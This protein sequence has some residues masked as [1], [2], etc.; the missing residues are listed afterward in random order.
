MTIKASGRSALILATGLFACV[1]GPSQATAVADNTAA[2]SK[3][4]SAAAAPVALN[5]Y[6]RHGWHHARA[7]VHRQ[8]SKLASKSSA[9]KKAADDSDGPAAIPPSVANANAELMPA[10]A[11]G[12]NARAMT[13]RADD[14]LQAASD[15]PVPAQPAAKTQVV[16]ADQLNDVDRALQEGQPPA[17]TAAVASAD[18]PSAPVVV[19]RS[20][21]STW[22]E[23]SLIGKIFIAF[24]G[25]LTLA[26]AAR[27]FM[28]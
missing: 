14:L 9:D 6:T 20:E 28:A 13:V 21:S 22:D 15:N 4:E 2:S 27:M 3:S 19:N 7:Y 25:L 16:S 24:G 10:D 12:S 5:K 18:T 26:S 17:P 8:S 11:P 1:V 23:T